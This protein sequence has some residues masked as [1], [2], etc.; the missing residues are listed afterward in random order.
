MQG[1]RV[2]KTWNCGNYPTAKGSCRTICGLVSYQI[3]GL[4]KTWTK[5]LSSSK[6]VPNLCSTLIR[7]IF[8]PKICRH[9][10]RSQICDHYQIWIFSR[11]RRCGKP[12]SHLNR[13]IFA[14]L[15]NLA[16]RPTIFV[17]PQKEIFFVP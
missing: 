8:V 6:S 13:T 15:P 3:F 4:T 16:K 17:L 5:S 11:S 2:P 9:Q 12:C 14:F 1:P 7:I 10:I